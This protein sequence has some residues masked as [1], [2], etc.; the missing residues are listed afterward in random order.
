MPTRHLLELA[1]AT[2]PVLRRVVLHTEAA[3][4]TLARRLGQSPS[5]TMMGKLYY[6]LT[7]ISRD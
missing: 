2:M 7:L 6:D 4:S 3:V 5:P 1:H